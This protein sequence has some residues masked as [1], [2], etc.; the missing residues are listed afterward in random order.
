[1]NANDQDAQMIGMYTFVGSGL[2]RFCM[3]LSRNGTIA[4]NGKLK[5][6]IDTPDSLNVETTFFQTQLNGS[7]SL[8][9]RKDY[10]DSTSQKMSW[11]TS[12][13][14]SWFTPGNTISKMMILCGWLK[15]V[16]RSQP[17]DRC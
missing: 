5:W 14:M 11:F 12:Q 13:K 10:W 8:N 17:V 7:A 16:K 1:M 4:P 6:N 3:G 2:M 15:D 9:Q